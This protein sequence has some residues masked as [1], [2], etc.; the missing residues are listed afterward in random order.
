MLLRGPI[1]LRPNNACNTVVLAQIMCFAGRGNEAIELMEKAM[2][3]SPYHPHWYLGILAL[4]Y[5]TAERYDEA[6][7]IAQQQFDLVKKKRGIWYGSDY[8]TPHF[9]RGSCTP[10]LRERSPKTCQRGTTDCPGFLHGRIQ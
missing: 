5:I 2:R 9:G 6:F 8:I 7:E 10:R 1:C 4:A 3:L